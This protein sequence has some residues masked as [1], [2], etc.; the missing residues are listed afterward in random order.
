MDTRMDPILYHIIQLTSI[1]SQLCYSHIIQLTSISSQ[2]TTPVNSQ[3]QFSH[4]EIYH[5]HVW[6]HQQKPHSLIPSND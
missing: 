2:I 5:L 4:S 6:M 1:S 3:L